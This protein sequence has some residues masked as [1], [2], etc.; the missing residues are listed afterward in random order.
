MK[1]A[2]GAD[3]RGF[4]LKNRLTMFLK[5]EGH[6]VRDFG[7]DSAEPCDY[8]IIGYNVARSVS[9]GESEKG[10]LICM[11]GIGMSIIANKVPG[12]RAAICDTKTDAELSRE[13]NDAN[14]IIISA[15]YVKDNP[16]DILKAWFKVRIKEERH[17]RRVDQIKEIERKILKGEM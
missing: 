2:I 5:A 16:Q 4:E 1:I 10:V 6:E 12:A 3:H 15:K 13:H 17:K 11:S 9:K 7:T 14:V 8:P